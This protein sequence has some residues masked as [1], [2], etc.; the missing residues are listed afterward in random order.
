ME[1]S[2]FYIDP[3]ARLES[4]WALNAEILNR[5][6]LTVKLEIFRA[7]ILSRLEDNLTLKF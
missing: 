3:V 6:F 5:Y 1:E 7:L 4:L 2:F